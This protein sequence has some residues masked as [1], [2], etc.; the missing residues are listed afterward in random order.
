M[1]IREVERHFMKLIKERD[2]LQR[3]AIEH[4]WNAPQVLDKRGVRRLNGLGS[5]QWV[6]ALSFNR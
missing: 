4:A 2:E 6:L 1:A 3:Y 5:G